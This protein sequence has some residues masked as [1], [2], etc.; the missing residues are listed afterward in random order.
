MPRSDSHPVAELQRLSPAAHFESAPSLTYLVSYTGNL[1]LRL[2]L[3]QL[4]TSALTVLWSTALV[5]DL[6]VIG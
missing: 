5:L 4:R 2:R 3:F 1:R 6:L